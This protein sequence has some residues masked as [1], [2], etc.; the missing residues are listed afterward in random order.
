M[1]SMILSFWYEILA[2]VPDQSSTSIADITYM[3]A[4]RVSHNQKVS[5]QNLSLLSDRTFQDQMASH[6]IDVQAQVCTRSKN[7]A[8]RTGLAESWS[9]DA[10]EFFRFSLVFEKIASTV[11]R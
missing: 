3:Y 11:P 1:T 2:K 4:S 8:L 6:R 10:L 7:A 9:D 5:E